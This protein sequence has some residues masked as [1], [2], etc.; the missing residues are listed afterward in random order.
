M[1]II[2]TF[3]DVDKGTVERYEY[4]EDIALPTLTVISEK[5]FAVM[6]TLAEKHAPIEIIK[7][8]VNI[9]S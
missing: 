8:E 1:E 4:R 2:V 3:Y 6:K 9:N 7:I 5:F